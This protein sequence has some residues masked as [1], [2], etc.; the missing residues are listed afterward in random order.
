ME[1]LESINGYKLIVKDGIL[2]MA[3]KR[4]SKNVFC[5]YCNKELSYES[6]LRKECQQCN[7]SLV[8]DE[9]ILQF[10]LKEQNLDS[11]IP[12]LKDKKLLDISTLSKMTSKDYKNIG[13][14]KKKDINNFIRAFSNK[15]PKNKLVVMGIIIGIICLTFFIFY[16][17]GN[18]E[19]LLAALKWI[20]LGI[21]GI[22][23]LLILCM[24]NC[25]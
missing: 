11:Y 12:L 1:K 3:R 9:E 23:V 4:Y 21:A 14:S 20:G 24:L 15:K 5:P 8:I 17:T 10:L 16:F 13:I 6:F 18:L 7:K 22:I 19:T 25:L 2:G